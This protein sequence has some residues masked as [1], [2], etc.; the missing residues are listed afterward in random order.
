MMDGSHIAN[1]EFFKLNG[2]LLVP[3]VLNNSE[4]KE[5]RERSL[6]IF[7]SG[8]WKRSA[9]NTE[10]ILSD[11]FNTFPEYIAITLKPAVL[12][13]VRNLLG[14]DPVLL[15]ETAVHHNF[16]AGWHKDT[17][18]QERAGYQFHKNVNA[19]MIEAG[20]YLQ[21]NSG[22]G[23]GLTVMEGSHLT[24]DPFL[25]PAKEPGILQRI[26]RKL[27]PNSVK[28]DRVMNP[29]G[30]KITD[31]RSKAGDLVIFDFRLNHKATRPASG[32]LKDIPFGKN[33]IA[34]FNAFSVHNETADLYLDYIYSR[35][36]PFYQHLRDTPRNPQLLKHANLHSFTVR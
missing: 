11:V 36:E 9:F 21:E 29:F 2:Y 30:H 18:S 6:E 12:E 31:I 27:L 10:N 1:R 33:K 19:L 13:H 7:K 17:T 35:K 24:P 28:A 22:H 20:F 4:V 34:F 15:P 3:G 23:G 8:E 26:R 16:Y 5:L 25:I 32:D 14:D